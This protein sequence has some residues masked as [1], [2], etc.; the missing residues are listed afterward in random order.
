MDDTY[1]R[2]SS[3]V[4][5]NN[6]IH[7]GDRILLSLSAG[8]DSMFMLHLLKRLQDDIKFEIG[9]F[10]L[11]H[12]TRGD[13][14]D[15]DESFV[16][17]KSAE[18]DIPSYIE[19]FDFKKNKI[20]A[21]SFEEHAR[22]VRYSL[23]KKICET[24][25][26]SKIATAHNMND[27]AETLLMRILS[28]TGITGLKGILPDVKN[29]IRPV[30]FAGKNEIYLYLKNN[31]ID[32]RED[33]SNNENFYLRNYIRN[34][35]IPSIGERFPYAEENLNNLASN[36]IE[37]QSLLQSLTERLYP[38]AVI[39]SGNDVII[40]IDNFREDIPLIKY[41]ISR[42]LNEIYGI[43]MKISLFNEITRRFMRNSANAVLYEKDNLIIRKSLLNDKMVIQVAEMPEDRQI[44]EI[45]S[46]S[47]SPEENSV[48]YLQEIKKEL[49]VA[50]E[51]YD[52]YNRN[53]NNPD[54]IFIQPENDLES[55]II[56]NRRP[57]DRIKIQNGTKK[58]K[59]LM[60]EKKLDTGI[61]NTIPLIVADDQI[62]AYLP[63]LVNSNN[64]RVSCNFYIR[65][66]TKRI[67]AFF[68]RDY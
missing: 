22:D 5:S 40:D 32:W 37:N 49:K 3:Y 11:N 61:K 39:K 7:E 9:V 57:G 12:L 26:Y 50:Y 14:T 16:R 41:Y 20:S 18:F 38:D 58:I 45:W 59:E 51:S 64:N 66:D 31:N 8:K 42:V 17:E 65:D 63:G 46:Y 1:N 35:I 23:L 15:K 54:I 27:N 44:S 13:E 43:K 30:L 56:R 55:I 29:I 10:H 67:L 53:K 52:F 28:G 2:F 21:V 19:R 24:E 4:L 48:I 36:A 62:A 60:I 25:N 47:V 34:I 6:L 68:F 33:L